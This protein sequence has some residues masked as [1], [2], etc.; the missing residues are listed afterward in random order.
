MPPTKTS[1]PQSSSVAFL[2][3]NTDQFVGLTQMI[4]LTL[5]V[6][7]KTQRS[8][9]FFFVTISPIPISHLFHYPDHDFEGHTIDEMSTERY[10][11]K[12]RMGWE[13][14]CLT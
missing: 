9:S 4:V 14:G 5:K 2:T 13:S 1:F 8:F 12:L 11:G 3:K 6:P 7:V 10:W